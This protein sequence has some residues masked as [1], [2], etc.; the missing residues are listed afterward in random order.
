MP[1]LR[2]SSCSLRRRA[3]ASIAS[4]LVGVDPVQDVLAESG[5]DGGV[6]ALRVADQEGFGGGP[7]LGG[8]FREGAGDDVGL[9]Q[10]EQPGTH[11]VP[12]TADAT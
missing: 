4:A 10:V 5:Q 1:R 6:K 2:Y 7:V 11:R 9:F 12:G 8:Q 3:A